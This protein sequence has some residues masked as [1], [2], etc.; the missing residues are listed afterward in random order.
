MNSVFVTVVV[1]VPFV[2]AWVAGRIAGSERTLA[3]ARVFSLIYLAVVAAIALTF[4]A[5]PELVVRHTSAAIPGL[6]A[7]WHLEL[8]GL[9]APFLPLAATLAAG[10]LLAAPR[11]ELDPRS[12]QSVLVATGCAVGVYCAEDLLLLAVFWIAGLAP[13]AVALHQAKDAVVR[14]KLARLYDVFFVFGAIPIVAAA[15]VVGWARARAGAALPFDLS[16]PTPLPAASAPTVFVLITWALLT[17]KAVAPLHSWL[18][19]MIERGPVGL[20]LLSAGTHLAAFLALRVMV[21]MLPEASRQYLP[22]VAVIALVSSLYQAIVALSQRDI[23]RAVGGVITSYLAL[24]LVG[25]GASGPEGLH[26]A[27]LQMLSLGLVSLGLVLTVSWIHARTGTTDLRELRGLAKEF[28][29]IAWVFFLLGLASVGAPGSIAWVAEDLLLHS[30]LVLHPVIAALLL[31][32]VVLNGVTILRVFFQAF[33]GQPK[34]AVATGVGDLRAREWVVAYAVIGAI[35]LLGLAPQSLIEL[36][37]S[38]VD[39]LVHSLHQGSEQS[40]HGTGSHAPA[41]SV[42]AHESL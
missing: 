18:P 10:V 28:P 26:G 33:F 3:F 8:D 36:R 14:K 7:R 21:P 16:E 6:R 4:L 32:V 29:R 15:F 19:V 25:I 41:S 30:L 37:R 38:T 13:G 40:H 39:S 12:V 5:H 22:I 35:A 23:R 31:V 34:G 42:N 27:M 2:A 9:S 17:R 1:F 24:V 11:R 20:A